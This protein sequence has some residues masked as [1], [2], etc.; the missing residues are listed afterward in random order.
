[1]TTDRWGDI[2]GIIIKHL[3]QNAPETWG[4][5]FYIT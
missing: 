4:L 1:M 3:H 2:D 5:Y